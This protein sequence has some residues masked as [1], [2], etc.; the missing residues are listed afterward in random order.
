MRIDGR[1]FRF[2][3][4]IER[5]VVDAHLL[6]PGGQLAALS[7]VIDSGADFTVLTHTVIQQPAPYVQPIPFGQVAIGV[8]GTTAMQALSVDL[9][10]TAISGQQARLSGPIPVLSSQSGLAFSA[11][12]RNAIDLFDLIYSQRRGLIALL[13]SPDTFTL[14][15]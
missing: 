7:L 13:T 5:P 3:D 1:W 4:G 6:L 12:G 9:V 14:S 8:G 15:S 10:L 2:P 11:L